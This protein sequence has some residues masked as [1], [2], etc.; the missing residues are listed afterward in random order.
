M[1]RRR[2]SVA[3][4]NRLS[5]SH[6]EVWSVPQWG[7]EPRP[8]HYHCFSGQAGQQPVPGP[9]DGA[10]GQCA[11]WEGLSHSKPQVTQTPVYPPV[12]WDVVSSLSTQ[13]TSAPQE[14]VSLQCSG[15]RLL[16]SPPFRRC[17]QL[18]HLVCKTRETVAKAHTLSWTWGCSQCSLTCRPGSAITFSL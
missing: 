4:R 17:L 1:P 16:F 10:V 18:R 2:D 15:C 3:H 8:A 6:R 14:H 13:L 7:W 5:C 11:E 9:C 12:T